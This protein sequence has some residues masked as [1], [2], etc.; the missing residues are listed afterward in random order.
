V[1]RVWSIPHS[2]GTNPYI[3]LVNRELELFGLKIIKP[4]R[5]I[6]DGI[7]EFRSGD[8][9]H[10][11]WPSYI[12]TSNT[13]ATAKA[14]LGLWQTYLDAV[15]SKGCKIIWTAHNLF[16]HENPFPDLDRTARSLL[17]SSC[18]RII[19]HCQCAATL[20]SQEYGSLPSVA[21]IPHPTLAE[22]YLQLRPRKE[23]RESLDICQNSFVFL[24]FGKLRAYKGIEAALSALRGIESQNVRLL[25]AGAP[26]PNYDLSQLIKLARTDERVILNPHQ[27]PRSSVGDFFQSADVSLH[28]YT[29]VLTSGAVYLAQGM[30]K[31]VIA[32]RIGCMPEA[33]PQACG[34]LYDPSSRGSLVSSMQRILEMD[35]NRMGEHA[36]TNI[37]SKTPKCFARAL[38]DIY[39]STT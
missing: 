33:V 18:S 37:A 20:L 1:I 31:P 5:N 2:S 34:L 28:C 38:M 36:R 12:Y 7:D 32:P 22:E 27:V 16:P 4:M 3:E 23:A 11:H 17:I 15:T 6:F 21:V 24:M 14:R 35:I 9:L 10:F 19:A 30:G 39:R 29:N 26:D 13:Y 8:I 25:I